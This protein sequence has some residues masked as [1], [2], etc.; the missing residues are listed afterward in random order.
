M[1]L[2]LQPYSFVDNMRLADAFICFV[3]CQQWK[4]IDRTDSSLGWFRV[5]IVFVFGWTKEN[6]QPG[7]STFLMTEII[8]SWSLSICPNNN[9]FTSIAVSQVWS[10]GWCMVFNVAMYILLQF[11]CKMG[12]LKSTLFFICSGSKA[13]LM[14]I[15]ICNVI[16]TRS[17]ESYC[18]CRV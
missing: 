9:R 8:R 6:F 11:F 18:V 1:W 10:L 13:I 7:C 12:F 3:S 15:Y 17:C 2:E 5:Q 16:F 4:E 14:S